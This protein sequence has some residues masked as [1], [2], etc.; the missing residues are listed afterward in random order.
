MGQNGEKDSQ[1]LPAQEKARYG[2][3]NFEKRR[4]PRFSIDLPI[5][6]YRLPSSEK[7]QARVSNISE[8]GIMIYVPE[9]L[10]IGQQLRVK[11][12][13]L[14]EPNLAAMEAIGEVVW[15]DLCLEE[16]NEYR[17]G[18]KFIEVS[19]DDLRRLKNFLHD[20]AKI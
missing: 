10:E 11:I 2:L 7:R 3:V 19:A 6:Y 8:G 4:Y 14:A 17:S 12:F 1:S 15:I 16:G 20:L 13:F 18:L 5:E 9:K